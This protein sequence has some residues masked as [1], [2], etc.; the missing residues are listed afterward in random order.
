VVEWSSPMWGGGLIF[1]FFGLLFMVVS[2]FFMNQMFSRRGCFMRSH[3]EDEIDDLK[4]EFKELKRKSSNCK[5]DVKLS[6]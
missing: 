5:A 6:M 4:R 1:P 3:C 2:L